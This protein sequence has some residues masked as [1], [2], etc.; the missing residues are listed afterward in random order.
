MSDKRKIIIA[1]EDDSKL[2]IVTALG[3]LQHITSFMSKSFL[4]LNG[5]VNEHI[6]ANVHKQK[7]I[8]QL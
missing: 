3:E 7:V 1:T 2:N 6:T 5:Y 8:A 4:T